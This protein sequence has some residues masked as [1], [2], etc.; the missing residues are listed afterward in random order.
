VFFGGAGVDFGVPEPIL[1]RANN[2]EN[3][4]DKN[5]KLFQSRRTKCSI[6]PQFANRLQLSIMLFPVYFACQNP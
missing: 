2:S 4:G 5:R 1:D 6:V 3:K